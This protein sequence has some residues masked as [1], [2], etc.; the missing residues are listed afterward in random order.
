MATG[1]ERGQVRK[2]RDQKAWNGA[3]QAVSDPLQELARQGARQMLTVVMKR[4]VEVYLGRRRMIA[5][6]CS[7]VMRAVWGRGR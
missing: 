7:K 3:R 2:Q 4:D 5:R 6:R 1:T